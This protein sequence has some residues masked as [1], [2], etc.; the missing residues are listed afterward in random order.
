MR[1]HG[2]VTGFAQIR[3]F[4]GLSQLSITHISYHLQNERK[5]SL[6]TG[7]AFSE[8]SRRFNGFAFPKSERSRELLSRAETLHWNA[9][10]FYKVIFVK[11]PCRK[12]Q[13]YLSIV[14]LYILD[15]VNEKCPKRTYTADSTTEHEI[16][17]SVRSRRERYAG[18]RTFFSSVVSVKTSLD[19]I[20]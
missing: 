8:V 14:K 2:K 15:K 4:W 7:G 16:Q 17:G 18:S 20:E 13:R 19:P 11:V 12:K 3:L 1:R 9:F 10:S 6:A 5:L